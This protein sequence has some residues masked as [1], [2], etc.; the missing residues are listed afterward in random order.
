M[1]RDEDIDQITQHT[2]RLNTKLTVNRNEINKL[3][4]DLTEADG[5]IRYLLDNETTPTTRSFLSAVYHGQ[6]PEEI[7]NLWIQANNEKVINNI[8]VDGTQKFRNDA[9][10]ANI[11][12]LQISGLLNNTRVT[13]EYPTI[14]YARLIIPKTESNDLEKHKRSTEKTKIRTETITTPQTTPL[15]ATPQPIITQPNLQPRNIFL[16]TETNNPIDQI[17]QGVANTNINT[18][19]N[20]VEQNQQ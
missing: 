15:R 3:T 10:E 20:Q 2:L 7:Q 13:H 8:I 5:L 9:P 17:T 11:K 12:I 19:N 14:K 18:T 6:K 16:P 4:T 1:E